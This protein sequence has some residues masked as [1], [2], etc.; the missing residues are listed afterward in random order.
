[1][2]PSILIVENDAA[3][4][5]QLVKA[6]ADWG[7]STVRAAGS[8][9]GARKVMA[10]NAERFS[11]VMVAAELPDGDGRDFCAGLRRQGCFTPV[12]LLTGPAHKDDVIRGLDAGADDYLAK[13]LNINELLERVTSQLRRVSARPNTRTQHLH[14]AH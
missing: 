3:I 7:G 4:C 6:L 14:G 11:L 13:P 12:I 1:M 2:R 10:E 8:I 9:S 5:R